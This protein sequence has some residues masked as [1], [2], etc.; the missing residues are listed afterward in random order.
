MLSLGLTPVRDILA[1]KR[2]VIVEDSI[3][4]GTT[5]KMRIKALRQAGAREIHM[6]VSCP[7]HQ[8]PCFYGIDFLTKGELIASQNTIDKIK[9]FIGLDSP[10][11]LSLDGMLAA[12][13]L[14]NDHF[15]LACFNGEYPIQHREGLSKL[16]LE[17]SRETQS[18]MLF[19][20]SARIYWIYRIFLS[21]SQFPPAHYREPLRPGGRERNWILHFYGVS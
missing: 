21:F 19:F 9:T 7:P 14:N 3:I 13:G 16:H 5:S 10:N 15:C 1:G 6:V 12:T 2:V 4:R 17:S 8:Y 11:Y 20:L 18:S